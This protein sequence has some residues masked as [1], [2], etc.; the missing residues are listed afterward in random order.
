M[1]D[2]NAVTFHQLEGNLPCQETDAEVAISSSTKPDPPCR[3]H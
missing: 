2:V 3:G 1:E